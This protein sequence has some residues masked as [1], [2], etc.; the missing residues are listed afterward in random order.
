MRV[1]ARRFTKARIILA[2][3]AGRYSICYHQF[4]VNLKLEGSGVLIEVG[5]KAE[6]I[7]GRLD[8]PSGSFPD[9]DLGP[10]GGR[11][12]GVSRRHARLVL[13]G[14]GLSYIMDLSS[15]N[16]T[17]L[18][19]EPCEPLA[20]YRLRDGDRVDLGELGL[21]FIEAPADV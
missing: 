17:C 6:L 20:H 4:M 9:V 2:R 19:G 13:V 21:I 11:D 15:T 16:G 14:G 3:L 10:H 12:A 5:D 8:E 7:L 18:N 1:W